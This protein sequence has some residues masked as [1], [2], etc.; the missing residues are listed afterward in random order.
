MCLVGRQTLLSQSINQS[1][2]THCS[3]T[4]NVMMQMMICRSSLSF[5]RTT[6]MHSAVHPIKIKLLDL[7]VSPSTVSKYFQMQFIVHSRSFS[8]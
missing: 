2:C 5:C 6:H 3:Q 7:S 4:N 1:M 8:Y